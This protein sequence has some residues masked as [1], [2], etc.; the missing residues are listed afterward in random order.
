MDAV[1]ENLLESIAT[2]LENNPQLPM[3]FDISYF[4][5]EL[6]PDQYDNFIITLVIDVMLEY[7]GMQYELVPDNIIITSMTGFS[8]EAE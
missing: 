5:R 3:S 2:S 4:K 7:P 6:P 1:Y 8:E